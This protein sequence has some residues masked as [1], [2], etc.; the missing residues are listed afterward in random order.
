LLPNRE[1][2]VTLRLR[3]RSNDPTASALADMPNLFIYAIVVGFA[4]LITLLVLLFF[5]PIVI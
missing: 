5:Y 1:M 3:L 2:D 4:V